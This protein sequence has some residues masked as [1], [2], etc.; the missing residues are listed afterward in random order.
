MFVLVGAGFCRRGISS[1]IIRTGMSPVIVVSCIG[2]SSASEKGSSSITSGGSSEGGGRF[3]VANSVRMM[4][5]IHLYT[6]MTATNDKPPGSNRGL[7]VRRGNLPS[8]SPSTFLRNL[9]VA[10]V[11]LADAGLA[12]DADSQVHHCDSLGG[13][14]AVRYQLVQQVGPAG[15]SRCI[16]HRHRP[17]LIWPNA[18]VVQSVLT[19]I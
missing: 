16:A 19:F 2:I 3:D 18:P 6:C 15:F 7:S 13:I 5:C 17:A 14:P 11:P 10:V 8:F 9:Q 4:C 1:P 12:P